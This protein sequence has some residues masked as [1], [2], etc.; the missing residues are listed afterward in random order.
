M[1]RQG[2]DFISLA[3]LSVLVLTYYFRKKTVDELTRKKAALI[4]VSGKHTEKHHP[5]RAT[6]HIKVSH[7]GSSKQEVGDAVTSTTA[8]EIFPLL[9]QYTAAGL[10]K[11][12]EPVVEEQSFEQSAD[13]EKEENQVPAITS[14][15]SG[16]LTTQTLWQ[17]NEVTR[18]SDICVHEATLSVSVEFADFSKVCSP[19]FCVR[20]C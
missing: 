13:I 5:Q 4:S 18:K 7:K 14:L 9:Q 12:R 6:L 3:G 11:P 1:R 16:S 15:K 20:M 17:W 10:S 2:T 19:T 8:Q